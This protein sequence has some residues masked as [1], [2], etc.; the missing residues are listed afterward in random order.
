MISSLLSI[1]A[2]QQSLIFYRDSKASESKERARKLPP[3][4][5]DPSRKENFAR[6]RVAHSLYFP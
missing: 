3:T 1:L 4:R 6:A 5:G 2:K